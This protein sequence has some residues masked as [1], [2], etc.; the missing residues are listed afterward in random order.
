MIC[1]DI[2]FK[3]PINNSQQI[4]KSSPRRHEVHEEKNSNLRG[5][6]PIPKIYRLFNTKNFEILLCYVA[7]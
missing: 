5:E 2:W 7:S 4:K 3:L 6:K 1:G